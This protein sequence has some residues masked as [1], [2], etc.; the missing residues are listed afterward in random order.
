M[1]IDSVLKWLFALVPLSISPGPANVLFAASGGA[2]GVK[3]T[4]PFW[5]GTNLVCILQSVAV[6]VGLGVLLL[7]FPN[8]SMLLKYAGVAVLGYLAIRFF[9]SGVSSE[10]VAKPLGFK[11]GVV[12]E[13]LNAKYLLIPVV[14][15]SQFY[16]PSEDGV[17]GLIALTISLAAL[18]MAS[19]FIWVVGGSFLI[20]VLAREW[21]A[22]YQ[23]AV[24]GGVL[25]ATAVWLGIG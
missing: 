8:L 4:V 13:L 16:S 24:F 9:R 23:G 20:S 7:R 18:T 11:E 5:L 3:S 22:K 2:F 1:E 15:F 19:N 12:V 10:A 14:M 17:T 25:L 6:G 21:V